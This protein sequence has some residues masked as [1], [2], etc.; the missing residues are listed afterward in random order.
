MNRNKELEES[1]SIIVTTCHCEANSKKA[2]AISNKEVQTYIP[3]LEIAT[4]LLSLAMTVYPKLF[5]PLA[6]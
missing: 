2:V 5:T 3:L 6:Q 1:E 4:A